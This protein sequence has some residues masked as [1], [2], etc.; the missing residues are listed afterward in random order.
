[1]QASSFNIKLNLTDGNAH[2]V[3][4]Y[5][6]DWDASR[7]QTITILDAATG[8]VLDTRSIAN[9]HNGEY[10]VWT[11]Q[12]NLIIQASPVNFAGPLV[13]ALLFGPG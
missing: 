10:A 13:G 9:F 3:A 2:R 11:L 4:V 12:G 1:M 5:F 6:L 7:T 8:A